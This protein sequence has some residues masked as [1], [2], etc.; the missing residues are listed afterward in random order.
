VN[1]LIDVSVLDEIEGVLCIDCCPS[2]S[3][4]APLAERAEAHRRAWRDPD[5]DDE[6]AKDIRSALDGEWLELEEIHAFQ[7]LRGWNRIRYGSI[8]VDREVLAEACRVLNTLLMAIES[9]CD[10][11]LRELADPGL[12][13]ELVKAKE[14]VA[15]TGYCGSC[16]W[17]TLYRLRDELEAALHPERAA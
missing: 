8:T 14:S 12:E 4:I 13:A 6:L 15:K 3:V 7:R 17:C 11:E 5:A 10:Q 2:P 9:E 1:R 16:R